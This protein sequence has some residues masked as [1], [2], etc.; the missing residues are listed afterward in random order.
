VEL[1][2]G[3]MQPRQVGSLS[4]VQVNV[5]NSNMQVQVQGVVAEATLTLAQY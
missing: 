5:G 1:A 3:G 4:E 2:A